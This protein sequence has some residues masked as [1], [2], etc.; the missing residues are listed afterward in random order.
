MVCDSVGGGAHSVTSGSPSAS[1]P[2]VNCSAMSIKD[3]KL[4]IRRGLKVTNV[5]FNTAVLDFQYTDNNEESSWL[6]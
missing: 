5:T 6:W 1:P 2:Q 4:A 3:I